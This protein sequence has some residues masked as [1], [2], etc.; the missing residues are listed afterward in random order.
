MGIYELL[1]K[2]CELDFYFLEIKYSERGKYEFNA[3]GYVI[4]LN[5]V[6]NTGRNNILK[7]RLWNIAFYVHAL[8]RQWVV[9]QLSKE[10]YVYDDRYRYLTSWLKRRKNNFE[11]LEYELLAINFQTL[12]YFYILNLICWH[13]RT[14]RKWFLLPR[15]S[16]KFYWLSGDS[17]ANGCKSWRRKHMKT[18][19]T[20]HELEKINL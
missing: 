18:S 1:R 7:Y 19:I 16:L 14:I 11:Q 12:P 13:R 3:C 17:R 4:R 5:N 8:Y 10:W 2:A 6:R 15:S 9:F 20:L